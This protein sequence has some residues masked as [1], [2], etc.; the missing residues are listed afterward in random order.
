MAA[1]AQIPNMPGFYWE[2]QTGH[3]FRGRHAYNPNTQESLSL[4]AA[5][6]VRDGKTKL[7]QALLYATHPRK[8]EMSKDGKWRDITFNSI[9]GMTRYAST[10]RGGHGMVLT[11]TGIPTNKYKTDKGDNAY[12]A[13]GVA[14]DASWYRSNLRGTLG[15]AYG[16]YGNMFKDPTNHPTFVLR[17]RVL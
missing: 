7:D 8:V 12:R 11:G 13:L 9:Y 6:G 15:E 3:G 5:A 10:R 14:R 2:Y 16:K 17:E 1:R 4:R